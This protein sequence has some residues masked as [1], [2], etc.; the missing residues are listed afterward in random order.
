MQFKSLQ[1]STLSEWCYTSLTAIVNVC[2]AKIASP[3]FILHSFT[4]LCYHFIVS[5]LFFLCVVL[6][7]SAWVRFHFH[8]R[9]R[10]ANRQT[11]VAHASGLDLY[12]QPGRLSGNDFSAAVCRKRGL[13]EHGD[14]IYFGANYSKH[15]KYVTGAWDFTD[16][17]CDRKGS[18]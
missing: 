13:F 4:L 18:L 11:L 3:W 8:L 2:Q 16:L 7:S 10:N 6:R 17:A 12:S 14:H 15:Q 5:L 9:Q 1:R